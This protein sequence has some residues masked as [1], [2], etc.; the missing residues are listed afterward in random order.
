MCGC[1]GPWLLT[2][3]GDEE[4]AWRKL[5]DEEDADSDQDLDGG[6]CAPPDRDG[7]NPT[8]RSGANPVPPDVHRSASAFAARQ[9]VDVCICGQQHCP[10]CFP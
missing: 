7:A 6:I 9:L 10:R 5:T 3:G 2:G 1:Q 8:T 4:D